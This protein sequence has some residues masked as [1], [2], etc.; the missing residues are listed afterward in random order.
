M[1]KQWFSSSSTFGSLLFFFRLAKPSTYRSLFLYHL[2]M[3]LIERLFCYICRMSDL[4]RQHRPITRGKRYNCFCSCDNLSGA[5]SIIRLHQ[6]QRR[7]GSAP[8]CHWTEVWSRMGNQV[9]D[10]KW[11]INTSNP[12]ARLWNLRYH[13][14]FIFLLGLNFPMTFIH[15]FYQVK[16]WQNR[17]SSERK[18]WVGEMFANANS[19]RMVILDIVIWTSGRNK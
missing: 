12:R 14:K 11:R 9:A 15:F 7:N 10:Y 13:T 17:R 16:S 2:I 6:T 1:I 19:T 18:N 4:Q 5:H 8:Q 3:L